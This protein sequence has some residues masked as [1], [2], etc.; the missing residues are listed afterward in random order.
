[1][2]GAR[3]IQ[4]S[5]KINCNRDYNLCMTYFKD[6]NN[7]K[8]DKLATFPDYIP[9]KVNTDRICTYVKCSSRKYNGSCTLYLI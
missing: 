1:M 8:Y 3:N 7:Y 5:M 9:C 6:V 4:F 2:F